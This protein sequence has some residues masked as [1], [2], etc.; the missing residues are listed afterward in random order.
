MPYNGTQF[1]AGFGDYAYTDFD[2]SAFDR[3]TYVLHCQTPKDSYKTEYNTHVITDVGDQ[4]NCWWQ[5]KE[6]GDGVKYCT[7][8]DGT[9]KCDGKEFNSDG[10][11][12]TDNDECAYAAGDDCVD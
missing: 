10:G 7:Q 11:S 4:E 8:F 12:Y 9:F 5:L 6:V 3:A 2:S 1:E